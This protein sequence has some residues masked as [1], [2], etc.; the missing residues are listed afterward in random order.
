MVE[1]KESKGMEVGTFS[2]D[3]RGDVEGIA[4]IKLQVLVDPLGKTIGLALW[5]VCFCTLPT[6]LEGSQEEAER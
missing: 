3:H 1:E 5:D 2:F 4:E 6:A